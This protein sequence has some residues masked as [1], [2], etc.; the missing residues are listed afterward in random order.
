MTSRVDWARWAERDRDLARRINRAAQRKAVYATCRVASRLGDGMLW[1]ALLIVLPWFGVQGRDCAWQMVIAGAV[2]LS[3][4][5]AVKRTMGRPRPYEACHEIQQCGR[6][7]DQFSFPSGHALHATT[8][9]LVLAAHFQPAAL[10]LA[11][12]AGL[13]AVSRI[14]LGLHY[15]SDVLAG[16][17]VGAASA[18]AVVTINFGFG[19]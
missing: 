16:I 13:I 18:A 7:L 17:A 14:V 12:L 10:L 1:Y 15:P 8:F 3:V 11:P 5:Y 4:Y 6:A 9:T 2:N 19:F